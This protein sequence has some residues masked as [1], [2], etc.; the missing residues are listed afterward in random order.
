VAFRFLPSDA[1]LRDTARH[2]GLDPQSPEKRGMLKQVQHDGA[3]DCF[4]ALR[5]DG[6]RVHA[7]KKTCKLFNFSVYTF[8]S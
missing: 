3:M 6:V 7:I 2:C 5:N 4:A 1:S 8:V